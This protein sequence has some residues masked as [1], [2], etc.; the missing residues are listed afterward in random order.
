MPKSMIEPMKRIMHEWEA[1]DGHEYEYYFNEAVVGKEYELSKSTYFIPF[2]TLHRVP[3]CGYTLFEKK[4]KLKAEFA[5]LKEKEILELKKKKTEFTEIVNT[6]IFSYTGDTQI[7]FWKENPEVLKSK[8][9]FL[10]ATYIDEQKKISSARDWG[11]TH[12]LEL[13]PLLGDFQ[14][15]KL[16][17]T[18]VSSRYS[19]KAIKAVLDQKIPPNLQGKIDFFPHELST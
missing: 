13:L 6:P 1:M 18:H 14:G 12:L 5:N 7:E 3:S 17:I 19:P 4:R 2:Q 11:H 16:V 9:L 15:E 8:V 10:E